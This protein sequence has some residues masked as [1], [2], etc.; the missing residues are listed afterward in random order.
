MKLLTIDTSTSCCSVA[1]TDGELLLGEYLLAGGKAVSSRLFDSI[2]HLMAD[3]GVAMEDLGGLGVAQGPGA[4]TGLRV[5]I[6]AVKGLSLATGLPI[7][8]FSSLAMLAMNVPMSALPV[9]TLYDA[10]KNEVY[11][12]L[13]STQSFLPVSVRPDAVIS[14]ESLIEWITGPTVLVGDGACRYREQLVELCGDLAI[15]APL[16]SCLPR[17]SNGALIALSMLQRGESL[18]PAELLPDYL[19]L[20]EAEIA[21]KQLQTI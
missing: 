6:A 12:G 3:C 1:L 7:A 20:S 2:E 17:A 13:Y 21:R 4:F 5:G 9:C 15:F 11:A 16:N 8:G 18:S 19:R 10:R 14:P